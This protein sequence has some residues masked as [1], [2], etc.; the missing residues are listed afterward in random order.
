MTSGDGNA[1][2]S[3][4]WDSLN[5]LSTVTDN[6][7]TGTS[8]TTTYTYDTAKNVVKV[9]YANG[10]Q[11]TLNYDTLNRLTSLTTPNTGYLDLSPFFR[12]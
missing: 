3:Y 8:N 2:V 5:R 4:T 11:A 6:R 1:S 7:L 12:T 9:A 10:V